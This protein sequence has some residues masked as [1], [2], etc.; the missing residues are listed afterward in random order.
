VACFF[1]LLALDGGDLRQL[2]LVERKRRLQALLR[3]QPPL[4]FVDHIEGRGEDLVAGARKLGLEG[5]VAKRANSPYLSGRNGAWKKIKIEETSD[6]V[7]IFAK[8]LPICMHG[9]RTDVEGLCSRPAAQAVE[10]HDGHAAI[11]FDLAPVA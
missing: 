2:P 11:E 3:D 1:D 9:T 10:L 7:V 4:V 5:V 8:P 6:F